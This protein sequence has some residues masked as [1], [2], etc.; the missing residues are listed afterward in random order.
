M[1]TASILPTAARGKRI[2][3]IRRLGAWLASR[4]SDPKAGLSLVT[5]FAAAAFSCYQRGHDHAA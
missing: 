1:S 3:T 4:A 2:P 5:G